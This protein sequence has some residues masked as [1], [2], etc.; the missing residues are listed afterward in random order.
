MCLSFST[1]TLLKNEKKNIKFKGARVLS[2]DTT[3][4][5]LVKLYD[6]IGYLDRA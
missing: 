3:K 1:L 4:T 5:E 2:D 6:L